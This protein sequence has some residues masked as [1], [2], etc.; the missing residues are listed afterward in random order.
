MDRPPFQ[1]EAQEAPRRRERIRLDTL[2]GETVRYVF[3]SHQLDGCDVIIITESLN[4]LTLTA[5]SD[6]CGESSDISDG[7]YYSSPPDGLDKLAD[8]IDTSSLDVLAELG[9]STQAEVDY[10]KLKRDTE[11]VHRLQ[12]RAAAAL[13]DAQAAAKAA[14]VN[15]DGP[16]G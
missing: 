13:A 5:Q 1:L 8:Y 11:R 10:I 12:A 4:W 15:L 7:D 9:I 14:G 2:A 16:P 6:G 3:E